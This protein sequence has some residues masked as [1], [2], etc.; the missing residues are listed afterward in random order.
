MTFIDMVSNPTS[1]LAFKKL[2]FVKFWCN[3][4][5]ENPQFSEKAIKVSLLSPTTYLSEAGFSL[6]TSIK[7]LYHNRL[8]AEADIRTHLDSLKSDIKKICKNVK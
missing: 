2:S 6:Y 1:Q 5:E 7:K 8:C 3:I 4:K